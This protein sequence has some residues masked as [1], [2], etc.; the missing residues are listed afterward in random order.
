MCA[1]VCVCAMNNANLVISGKDRATAM[2]RFALLGCMLHQC[3]IGTREVMLESIALS[4]VRACHS[5]TM[6][7]LEGNHFVKVVMIVEPILR[8][9]ATVLYRQ[10]PDAHHVVINRAVADALFPEPSSNPN[11]RL[12][13]KR[14]LS[15]RLAPLNDG[16]YLILA[17][18][19]S[20]CAC[21]RLSSSV[22]RIVLISVFLYLSFALC[23]FPFFY[24]CANAE[25]S[26]G[27][28]EGRI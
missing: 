26:F 2:N 25:K 9:Y 7:M 22:S 4:L 17:H 5:V 8:K 15:S 6:L 24:V 16:T 12:Q 20:Y 14:V 19:R 21:F 13:S 23:L 18:A 28:I 3:D 11:R 10:E 1:C 27:R